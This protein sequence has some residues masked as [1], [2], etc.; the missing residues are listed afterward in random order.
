MLGREP[1]EAE[2]RQAA[3]VARCVGRKETAPFG[4]RDLAAP[5]S[6]LSA[7]DLDAGEILFRAGEPSSAVFIV[8][9][10]GFELF[11]G[12][13]RRRV[14]VQ[15][16]EAGD[17]DGDVQLILEM[18]HLYTSRALDRSRCLELPAAGFERLVA[19]HPAVARRWLS[20]I[21][22]RLAN[23]QRRILELLGRSL[24][25]QL[26]QLILDEAVDGRVRL[27]QQTLA[28]ML[29]VHRPSTNR[30][31]REF[32]GR[33]IVDLHYGEITIRHP[34]LLEGIA[35]GRTIVTLPRSR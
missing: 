10:G 17:V 18:P 11:V 34:D 9:E 19:E 26:A 12:S 23:S 5:A 25:E 29:G 6:Y 20:S 1:N 30:V 35:T 28:A 16:L 31:L 2:V 7:R 33:G 22:S 14:I 13:G 32:E 15:L 4:E 27:T 3:W 8:Q 24:P 21:G